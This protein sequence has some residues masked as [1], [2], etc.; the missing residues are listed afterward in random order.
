MPD[1]QPRRVVC[2]DCQGLSVPMFWL[3]PD[4]YCRPCIRE[5]VDGFRWPDNHESVPDGR[6]PETRR[7]DRGLEQ[8]AECV[9]AARS[10]TTRS[11]SAICIQS[12]GPR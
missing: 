8:L 2:D 10:T 5:R 12:S 1:P 6:P 11:T 4:L 7:L 9:A 3:G